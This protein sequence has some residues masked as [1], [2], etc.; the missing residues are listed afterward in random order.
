MRDEERRR[1]TKGLED[2]RE[3]AAIGRK[4]GIGS[5][6]LEELLTSELFAKSAEVLPFSIS[7]STW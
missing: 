7:G 6:I 3:G 2:S 1:A 4:G 5:L